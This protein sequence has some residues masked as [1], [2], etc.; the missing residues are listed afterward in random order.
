VLLD[1][2]PVA[3]SELALDQVA[4]GSARSSGCTLEFEVGA[5]KA[6]PPLLELT[7]ITDMVFVATGATPIRFHAAVVSRVG[8][9]E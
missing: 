7:P 5:R 2:S 3:E 1:G 8:D 4:V 9:V 6:P